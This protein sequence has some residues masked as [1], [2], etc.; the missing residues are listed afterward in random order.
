MDPKFKVLLY[1]QMHSRGTKLL[2]ENCEVVYA[3][4][5]GEKDIISQVIFK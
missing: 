3:D 5:L 4:S 2:E 1:E